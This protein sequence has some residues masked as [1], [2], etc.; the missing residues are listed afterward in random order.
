MHYLLLFSL[1][2]LFV[3]GCDAVEL[4]LKT[5]LKKKTLNVSKSSVVYCFKMFKNK[6]HSVFSLHANEQ[7]KSDENYSFSAFLGAFC[8]GQ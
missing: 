5:T 6:F 1:T 8:G 3:Y 2:I 4:V 7:S